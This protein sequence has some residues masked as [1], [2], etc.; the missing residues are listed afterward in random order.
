MNNALLHAKLE[1]TRPCNSTYENIIDQFCNW[2]C[3]LDRYPDLQKAFGKNN[4]EDARKHWYN[5]GKKENRMCTCFQG[6]CNWQCYLDRYPDLQNAFGKT[7]VADAQKHW[8]KHGKDEK[9]DCTCGK[10]NWQCYL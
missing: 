6:T 3:Y 7:N 5:H 1:S 10:C 2:Q 9:R 8:N 4:V